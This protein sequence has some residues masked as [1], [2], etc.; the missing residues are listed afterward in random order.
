MSA[1]NQRPQSSLERLHPYLFCLAF[2]LLL[3]ARP[4]SAQP[5]LVA[6]EPRP[7]E[8]VSLSSCANGIC[9]GA[10]QP[11]SEEAGILPAVLG[12][13]YTSRVLDPH[14]RATAVLKNELSAEIVAAIDPGKKAW[15]L[16]LCLDC[17]G[18]SREAVRRGILDREDGI[19]CQSCHGP[20]G[21]WW[22]RHF[23]EDWNHEKSVEAGLRDLRSPAVRAKVCLSCHLG[24][25]E[26]QVDHRLFAAGH[27]QLTFEL[28][29]YSEQKELRHWL[30]DSVRASRDGRR[31]SHGLPAWATGQ[32]TAF[33]QSL[34]L[35]ISRSQR[36]QGPWPDYADLTC[37]S[38]HHEIGDAS[39]RRQ[40]GYRFRGGQPPFSTARWLV[41]RELLRVALPDALEGVEGQ[42]EKLAEEIS[43]GGERAKIAELA[44]TLEKDLGT[45]TPK[46]VGLR[47]NEKKIHQVL[48]ALAQRS[49]EIAADPAAARQAAFSAHSLTTE[50]LILD[51]R[52]VRS[53]LLP[54]VDQLFN[55]IEKEGHFDRKRF[56]ETLASLE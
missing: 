29:N 12:N 50:L 52:A 3:L 31:P 36:E 8:F 21:G 45:L 16:P 15:Q 56:A 38:C 19:S 41:L 9:H 55:L 46:L 33:R 2:C 27:P 11:S 34:E 22:N 1:Q 51:R 4:L 26:R 18:S 32:L 42:V 25:G 24:Q 48:A 10:A 49:N 47:L 6:D 5:N 23:D 14:F 43:R 44:R 39:W 13:E 17:H 35:I 54:K 37:S 53:G 7:G 40:P 30:P 20:A 28:D